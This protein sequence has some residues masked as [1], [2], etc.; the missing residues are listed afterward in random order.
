MPGE[1]G[2]VRDDDT[3]RAVFLPLKIQFGRQGSPVQR[4]AVSLDDLALEFFSGRLFG[5]EVLQDADP[6]VIVDLGP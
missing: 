5:T 6:V 2:T 4:D 1:S 3:G